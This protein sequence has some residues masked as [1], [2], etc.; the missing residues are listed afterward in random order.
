MKT[1]EPMS[2]NQKIDYST[3]KTWLETVETILGSH[4]YKSVLHYS[5]LEC[6]TGNF[7]STHDLL[8]VKGEHGYMVLMASGDNA[9]WAA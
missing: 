6:Y 1:G 5:R 7:P 3:L 2:K 4:E 8:I 9:V